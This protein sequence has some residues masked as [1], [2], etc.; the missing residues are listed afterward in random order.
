M[1]KKIILAGSFLILGLGIGFLGGK[2]SHNSSHQLATKQT[3]PKSS[4]LNQHD[5]QLFTAFKK[6]MIVHYSDKPATSK[7]YLKMLGKEYDILVK[8]NANSDDLKKNS[9]PMAA[10]VAD[11]TT[12]IGNQ[13]SAYQ[14]IVNHDQG[15]NDFDND[16]ISDRQAQIML[17]E[18]R[19][20]SAIYR[21]NLAG[22]LGINYR[23]LIEPYVKNIEEPDLD[24]AKKIKTPSWI[25]QLNP[26]APQGRIADKISVE[27]AEGYVQI[28]D[29]MPSEY[30]GFASE[31]Q[32]YAFEVKSEA[33]DRAASDKAFKADQL[34]GYQ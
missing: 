2:F 34:T 12:L 6:A 33:D 18:E 28:F 29:F 16:A 8:A 23:D 10:A 1:K 19:I 32:D 4:E 27:L 20:P 26:D 3:T 13:L 9:T 31:S 17:S 7:E 25:R 30:D 14:D 21:V 5:Q 11:Y 24:H 15:K 22:D